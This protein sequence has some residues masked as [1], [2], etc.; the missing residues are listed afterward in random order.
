M[1]KCIARTY[2]KKQQAQKSRHIKPSKGWY[3][4]SFFL[5]SL[6]PRFSHAMESKQTLGTILFDFHRLCLMWDAGIG[7]SLG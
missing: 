1:C 7:T 2:R 4:N 3:V 6:S 5:L